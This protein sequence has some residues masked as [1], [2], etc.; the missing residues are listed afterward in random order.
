MHPLDP[1]LQLNT[2]FALDAQHF[3]TVSLDLTQF[4]ELYGFGLL[5]DLRLKLGA[6]SFHLY[7]STKQHDVDFGSGFAHH[8]YCVECWFS[9]R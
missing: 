9:C 3:G 5:L 8:E 1:F 6:S 4:C 7:L 2:R